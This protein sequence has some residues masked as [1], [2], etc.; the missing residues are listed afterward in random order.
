[1][2]GSQSTV[3]MFQAEAKSGKDA[4]V[5]GFAS[6]MLPTLQ[7][8]MKLAQTVND[9]ARPSRTR[10]ANPV[11]PPRSRSRLRH[12]PD[13]RP[14]A[15]LAAIGYMAASGDEAHGLRVVVLGEP[16]GGGRTSGPTS[17]RQRASASEA[18]RGSDDGGQPPGIR[19][20]EDETDGRARGTTERGS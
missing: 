5:K 8:Y 4:D 3:A 15:G 9:A 18:V 6:K 13:S 10:G 12:R 17:A 7:E 11:R 16:S 19:G 14:I 1:M 20:E 2:G